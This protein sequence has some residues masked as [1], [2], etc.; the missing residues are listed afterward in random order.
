M[1]YC[2]LM[3][4]TL[5][6]VCR[7]LVRDWASS[8]N[9]CSSMPYQ[10]VKS[11]SHSLWV[12]LP[13]IYHQSSQTL[14]SWPND[15]LS[16]GGYAETAVVRF[17]VYNHQRKISFCWNWSEVSIDNISSHKPRSVAYPS[18]SAS[19]FHMHTVQRTL[20]SRGPIFKKS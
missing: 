5:D 13:S 4:N 3:S 14:W 15:H 2:R 16:F 9:W 6:T 19:M 1:S 11:S 7:Q 17:S 20:Q 10:S 18:S 12:F 8:T